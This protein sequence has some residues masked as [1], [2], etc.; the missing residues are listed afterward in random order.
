MI[1]AKRE[2]RVAVCLLLEFGA[3]I[4][5][6]DMKGSTPLLTASSLTMRAFLLESG[7][8]PDFGRFAGRTAA[9]FF[10]DF[11]S[12]DLVK[13]LL[14]Y[15]ADP[16]EKTRGGRSIQE[17]VD[18]PTSEWSP[19]ENSPARRKENQEKILSLSE[20]LRLSP[21]QYVSRNWGLI[22]WAFGD[23]LY[24][25]PAVTE[26]TREVKEILSSFDRIEAACRRHLEGETLDRAL[27]YLG[28]ESR[29]AER[30]AAK[31]A[32]WS[33]FAAEYWANSPKP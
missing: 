7:A 2:N 31:N 22:F 20:G 16:Q 14:R 12:R 15:G 26:W 32:R 10:A 13:L 24:D 25:D 4:D 5:V 18:D 27:I 33:D 17:V 29:K 11:G 30:I 19:F 28:R 8:T 9:A 21:E 3:Q 23:L 6:K 1:A